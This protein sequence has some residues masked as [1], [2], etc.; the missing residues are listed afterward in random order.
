[1][2]TGVCTVRTRASKSSL[3]A[4]YTEAVRIVALVVGLALV[5]VAA[6][7][8]V[9]SSS[10]R[11][12]WVSRAVADIPEGFYYSWGGKYLR[13]SVVSVSYTEG[14]NVDTLSVVFDRTV[15][16]GLCSYPQGGDPPKGDNARLKYNARTH[17]VLAMGFG[18]RP[19]WP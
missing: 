11:P 7:A 3:G 9:G 8:F 14:A 12:D 4:A 16:C 15:N 2:C 10:G 19:V 5:G 6:G 1:V 17:E 18:Y 13:P